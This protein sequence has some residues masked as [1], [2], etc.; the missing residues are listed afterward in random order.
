M[1]FR[2]KMLEDIRHLVF[3]VMPERYK[4]TQNPLHVDIGMFHKDTR[5]DALRKQKEH[6]SIKK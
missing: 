4:N 1:N 6:S 5:G 3:G 2:E